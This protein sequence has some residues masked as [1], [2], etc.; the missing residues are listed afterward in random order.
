MTDSVNVLEALIIFIST[1]LPE[2]LCAGGTDIFKI[3]FIHKSHNKI[4]NY[5][6]VHIFGLI[7]KLLRQ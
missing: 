4:E 7:I 3:L 6:G 5:F 1:S 2:E